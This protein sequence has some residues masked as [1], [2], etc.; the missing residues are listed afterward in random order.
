MNKFPV[1]LIK[2]FLLSHRLRS[3][4]CTGVI[5]YT[6]ETFALLY[7]VMIGTLWHYLFCQLFLGTTR[8][9]LVG[10]MY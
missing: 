10:I 3:N 1:V 4:L 6:S 8:G 5:L 9:H 2:D 7:I